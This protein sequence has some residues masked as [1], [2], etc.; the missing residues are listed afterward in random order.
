MNVAIRLINAS[1]EYCVEFVKALTNSDDICLRYVVDRDEHKWGVDLLTNVTCISPYK[2]IELL[3]KRE[4]DK[5]VILPFSGS[6]SV[7]DVI[8][9]AL[10]MG[11]KPLMI[12]APNIPDVAGLKTLS[13]LQLESFTIE[14]FTTIHRLQVHLADHCNLN[15][16]SCS[17]FSSLVAGEVFPKFEE[18]RNDLKKVK[19]LVNH[20][21]VLD[22]LG[23][24]PFLNKEWKKYVQCARELFPYCKLT[25]ITNGLMF[26]DLTD[27]DWDYMKEY[28][29]IF[30]MSLYKPMWNQADSI[31]S[32]LRS[33]NVCFTLENLIYSRFHQV[34]N[35]E[36]QEDYRQKRFRCDMECYQL[37]HGKMSPCAEMMY[38]FYYNRFF[39]KSLPTSVPVENI[40][41][42]QDADEL[43][44][45]LKKPMQICSICQYPNKH[46]ETLWHEWKTFK[47]WKHAENSC[48]Y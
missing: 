43:L 1:S 47:W 22:F 17:H 6:K 44:V 39:G 27:E 29:V 15:C 4:L 45:L 35:L 12:C 16:A 9:E 40:Y 7:R 31:V 30:R 13:A 19:E 14:K 18:V 46:N 11:A 38:S 3:M 8:K 26:R 34:F 33:K 10:D 37:Y 20:I 32:Y 41:N 21:D 2:C 24:E 28:N 48:G 42:I 23:G 25:I 36:D 5:L